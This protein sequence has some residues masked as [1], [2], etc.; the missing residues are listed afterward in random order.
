MSTDLYTIYK[1]VDIHADFNNPK[2]VNKGKNNKKEKDDREVYI[3][4]IIF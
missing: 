2:N 3:D 4:S 1:L